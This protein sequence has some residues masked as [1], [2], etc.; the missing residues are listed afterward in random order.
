VSGAGFDNAQLTF[1]SYAAEQWAERLRPFYERLPAEPA[2][3]GHWD[4]VLRMA[5]GPDE[6]FGRS[7]GAA[8]PIDPPIAPGACSLTG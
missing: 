1:G 4:L 3:E 6:A 8:R 2:P 5:L 7:R